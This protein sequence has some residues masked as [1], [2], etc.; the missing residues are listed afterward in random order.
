MHYKSLPRTNFCMRARPSAPFTKWLTKTPKKLSP[1]TTRLSAS[2]TNCTNS[3][4][5]TPHCSRNSKK[6]RRRSWNCSSF[7]PIQRA[8]RRLLRPSLP[9]LIAKIWRVCAW[10]SSSS[11]W[12]SSSRKETSEWLV[13]PRVGVSFC[14][15]PCPAVCC[16]LTWM[17][18]GDKRTP[19][20]AKARMVS[21]RIIIVLWWK[22]VWRMWRPHTR[23]YIVSPSCVCGWFVVP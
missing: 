23:T 20:W 17:L 18:T 5:G 4:S 1:W 6:R 22:V 19:K 12:P 11:S 21:M 3:R 9:R 13:G 2:D 15:R 7:R 10:R 16:Q 14:R 8:R